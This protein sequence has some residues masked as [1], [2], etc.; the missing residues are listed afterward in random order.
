MSLFICFSFIKSTCSMFFELSW[1]KLFEASDVSR[2]RWD[3]SIW[4][5]H[6]LETTSGGN[7][8][9][10]SQKEI[11]MK[12]IPSTQK[13][14]ALW[15]K[16]TNAPLFLH[17][18]SNESTQKNTKRIGIESSWKWGSYCSCGFLLKKDLDFQY[19]TTIDGEKNPVQ[20]EMQK[21]HLVY[22]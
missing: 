10:W 3:S 1:G 4:T 2:I 16:S 22:L 14:M 17:W 19:V 13:F 18:N 11:L 6:R 8:S 7:R 15:L 12:G 9:A 20:V 21:K 5:K